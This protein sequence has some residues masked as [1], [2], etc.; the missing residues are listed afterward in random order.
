MKALISI[1]FCLIT[2]VGFSQEWR[3]SLSVARK[4]Y[5]SGEYKK[6]LKYYQSAQDKAPES[7]DFSDEIGQS[8][9]KAREFE[10]AEKVYQQSASTKKTSKQRA[11]SYHNLGNASLENCTFSELLK[12]K[13]SFLMDSNTVLYRKTV[14][15]YAM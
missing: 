14:L 15:E 8:A 6:A 9:Y 1:F 7:I 10:L 3:D 5:K 4:A 2:A 12:G 13:G 11:A